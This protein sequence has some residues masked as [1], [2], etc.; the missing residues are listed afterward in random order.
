MSRWPEVA[1]GEVIDVFDHKRVP[2][3]AAQRS[4]RKGDYPYYGAQGV[5]DSI[6]DYIFDGRYILIPEDGENLRSR[7]L[8]IAY[9]ADGR[10]WVNNHAHIVRAKAGVAIDR[11]IQSA[12]EAADIGRWVIG[13]AQP[14]LSQANLRKIPVL[15]P[16]RGEQV[17]IAWILDALVDLICNNRRSVEVLEE[18]A[19]T[20]YREWFVHY[21]YPGHEETIFVDSPVG[22]IPKGW[23]AASV[24]DVVDL[25]KLTVDPNDVDPDLPAVGLEHIPRRQLTLDDWGVAGALGSRKAAISER[26]C[27]VRE[28]PAVLPQGE[29]GTDRRDLFN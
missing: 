3:S 12:I 6:D 20:I 17:T 7:K 15:L 26:R 18:M 1:L 22:A 9:F 10:F 21:R 4:I 8:P 27:S 19:R 23:V 28:D 13:A 29:R 11:F 14:K 25:R 5:I 24:S 2:L 16:P